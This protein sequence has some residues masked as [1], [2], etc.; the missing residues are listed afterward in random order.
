MAELTAAT[1]KQ[2][3]HTTIRVTG[4]LSGDHAESMETAFTELGNAK[5]V[6]LD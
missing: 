4:Y 6:L 3:S 1:E 5:H 2:P